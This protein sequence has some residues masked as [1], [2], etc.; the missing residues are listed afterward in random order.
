MKIGDIEIHFIKDGDLEGGAVF[1]IP[2]SEWEEWETYHKADRR[3]RIR[4]SLTTPPNRMDDEN[5][6]T[7]GE[8]EG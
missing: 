6:P 1:G 4:L 2:K 5:P 8:R 3:N 7:D